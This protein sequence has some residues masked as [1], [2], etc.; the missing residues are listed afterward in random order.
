MRED[1]TP[2]LIPL[3]PSNL[4]Q[5]GRLVVHLLVAVA[6]ERATSNAFTGSAFES[7][8]LF[9]AAGWLA[10]GVGLEWRERFGKERGVDSVDWVEPRRMIPCWEGRPVADWELLKVVYLDRNLVV[11]RYRQ[12]PG[13]ET[14]ALVR[15]AEP[16]GES[17]NPPIPRLAPVLGGLRRLE[18][19]LGGWKDLLRADVGYLVLATDAVGGRAAHRVRRAVRGLKRDRGWA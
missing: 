7:L 18:G 13:G 17:A 19:R 16:D 1:F 5:G 15:T 3:G 14:P 2:M 8:G 4:L 6:I 9:L 10:L 12:F 11:F